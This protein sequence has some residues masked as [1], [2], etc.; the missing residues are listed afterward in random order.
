MVSANLAEA[1][2]HLAHY[3]RLV[4]NGTVVV[5]C[6]RNKPIAE[7]RPIGH[8]LAKRPKRKIGLMKGLCPV[9]FNF[10]QEDVE[11]AQDF[12]DGSIFPTSATH[13]GL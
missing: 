7:I 1:K 13:S 12:N 5:L 2:K 6:E 8:T 11:I 9:G 4:K 10:L 3:T